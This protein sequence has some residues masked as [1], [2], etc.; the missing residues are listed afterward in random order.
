MQYWNPILK[1]NIEHIIEPQYWTQYW[2]PILNSILKCNLDPKKVPI[3]FLSNKN[4]SLKKLC[5]TWPVLTGLDQSW[6][7]LIFSNFAG[8]VPTWLVPHDLF[9]LD[10]FHMTCPEWTCFD[11][12]RPN[13]ICS[14]LTCPN[15][16]YTKL[17]CSNLTSADL[18]CPDL[19][20]SDL[21]C[22]DLIC[23]NLAYP[24]LT[25]PNF[26]WL[27]LQTPSGHFL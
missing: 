21:T 18:T 11:S 24:N 5:P 25:C 15:M 2:I 19:I 12:T 16:T 20:S 6:L 23:P 13:L 4:L 26:S 10:L 14:N 17:T 8:P 1:P 7:K 9:Q 3:K 22:P 27:A